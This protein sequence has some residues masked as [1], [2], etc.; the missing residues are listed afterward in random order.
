MGCA[1]IVSKSNYPIDIR[2]E[3]TGATVVITDKRGV[4]IFRGNTPATTTMQASSGYFSKGAYEVKIT[5][6]GY[7]PR[8]LPVVFSIDGWYFGNLLLGGLLGMLIIDPITGAM[9]K[10]KD[11]A[12]YEK[13]TRVGGDQTVTPSLQIMG[14]DHVS[15]DIKNQLERIK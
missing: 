11:P 8:T 15:D 14:I 13:L 5:A 12:I 2:T 6:P 9:W 1:S 3:P 7:E 4:E 10:L